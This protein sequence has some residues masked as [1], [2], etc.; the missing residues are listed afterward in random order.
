MYWDIL[1]MVPQ[2][3]C[4]STPFSLSVLEM[5]I[6]SFRQEVSNI[7]TDLLSVMCVGNKIMNRHF[8]N[9]KLASC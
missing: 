8:E 7:L 4:F 2:E 1:P 5:C 9:S 6:G 3:H